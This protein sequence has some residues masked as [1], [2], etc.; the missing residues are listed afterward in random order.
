MK[1]LWALL[2]AMRPRQWTKNLLLFAGLIF[3]H[4]LTSPGRILMACAGFVCFCCLSS[5]VYLI[6]DLRDRET[7]REHPTK[8]FRPLASGELSAS[9]AIAGAIALVAIAAVIAFFLSIPFQAAAAVYFG[10]MLFYSLGLKHVVVL[11]LMIVAAGFVLRAIAGVKAIELAGETID[12]TPWFT[13]CVFFLALFIVICKRRHEIV[14]LSGDALQHRPVL[15]HYTP[16]FL[17][18]MIS[19]ATAA[20][21]LSYSLYTILGQPLGKRP[22]MLPLTIPFV[23]FGVFRYLYLVY[24]R[25]EGGAPEFLILEDRALQINVLLW[26]LCISAML[27]F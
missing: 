2:R 23:L 13:I 15:E 14:L 3:S 22:E 7:D 6:N 1:T 21:V 4:H 9:A 5:A 26:V 16:H 20:T 12:V 11:D 24:G 27:Y 18:Q 8:K 10:L 25:N 17:D 19:V